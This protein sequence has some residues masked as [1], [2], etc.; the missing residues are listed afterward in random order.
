MSIDINGQQKGV[1]PMIEKRSGGL[2]T[3][4]FSI[5]DQVFCQSPSTLKDQTQDPWRIATVDILWPRWYDEARFDRAAIECYRCKDNNSGEFIFV[6]KDTD[7]CIVDM[8]HINTRFTKG[9][10]VVFKTRME[11]WVEGTVVNAISCQDEESCVGYSIRLDEGGINSRA[12]RYVWNDMDEWIAGTDAGPRQRL[13]DAIDQNC[14]FAHLNHLVSTSTLDVSSF[15]DLIVARAIQA[16]S[17]DALAWI[18]DFLKINL[19][20]IRDA[21]GNGLLHQISALPNAAR[22][23]ERAAYISDEEVGGRIT[24]FPT[25]NE[26]LILQLDRRGRFFLH[27]LV[28]SENIRAMDLALTP[29]GRFAWDLA[30]KLL[31]SWRKDSPSS[32]PLPIFYTHTRDEKRTN[33]RDAA[34][35]LGRHDM[36]K[37]IDDYAQWLTAYQLADSLQYFPELN[38]IKA[39]ILPKFGGISNTA[40]I[41]KLR[42]FYSLKKE[43]SHFFS[44]QNICGTNVSKGNLPLLSWL[45]E[46]DPALLQASTTQETTTANVNEFAQSELFDAALDGGQCESMGLASRAAHGESRYITAT[47]EARQ[48]YTSDVLARYLLSA[49]REEGLAAYIKR[50]MVERDSHLKYNLH[51]KRLLDYKV[52]LLS[53]DES[54]SQRLEMLE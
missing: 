18:Q 24:M 2:W 33:V 47:T 38:N 43:R 51:L 36:V 7:Y 32:D 3:L 41:R 12:L 27:H 29:N 14:N 52:R 30:L 26:G 42:H 53:D 16:C 48:F 46:G 20:N 23:F 21:N 34:K 54:I 45:V 11:R 39:S 15:R 37:M 19:D 49:R 10:R 35:L 6:R 4:R 40:I 31:C 22:F 8:V 44:L 25:D 13:F 17:Y 50:V 5:G 1:F 28:A 9:N